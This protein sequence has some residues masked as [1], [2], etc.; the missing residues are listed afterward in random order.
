MK[1]RWLAVAVAVAVAGATVGVVVSGSGADAAQETGTADLARPI[2]PKDRVVTL[3]TGDKVVLLGGDEHKV[4]IDRGPG[5][6]HVTFSTQRSEGKL[7]VMP[8]DAGAQVAEG[9]LDRR[10]FEVSTLLKF[11]YE[12]AKT[13]ATPLII[14]YGASRARS[15]QA[16]TVR[17]NLPA[18]NGAAVSAPKTGN[19]LQQ[20]S[21]QTRSTSAIAKVWLDGKR[22]IALDQ[23]VPQ[24][25]APAAWKAGFTGKGMSVAV[26]DTGIDATHPDLQGKITAEKN[27]TT[28]NAGD[29]IG[30]GTHVASTIAGTGA[31]SNGKYKGVAPDAKLLD[32]KVCSGDDCPES[33]M[34][35]GM[36]WAA[37]DQKAKIINM[38]IGGQDTPDVDPLEEAVNRLSAQTG[39]LFVICAG[40]EGEDGGKVDSPGSADAALTVGA[41]D[42]KDQYAPFS[43]PGP[44]VGDGGLKPDITAPGVDI[45]AAKSKDSTIGDPVG[46][47]YL[48]MSGTSMATPHVA[49]SAALMLQQHPG[50]TGPELKSALM[51]TAKVLPKQTVFQQGAGRVD[52]AKAITQS[53]VA[54]PGSLSFGTQFWPHT[55]DKPLVKDL[56]YRNLGTKPVTLTLT[57]TATKAFSF[58]PT[59]LTIPAGGTGAVKVTADTRQ[60]PIGMYTGRVTATGDGQTVGTPFAIEKEQENYDVTIKHLLPNGQPTDNYVTGIV[61]LADGKIT[62]V[63]HTGQGIAKV[64]LPRGRYVVDATI[65]GDAEKQYNL[66]WPMIDLRQNTVL[67]ADAKLAKPFGITVP[68]KDAKLTEMSVGYSMTSTGDVFERST[69]TSDLSKVFVASLG[70][71]APAKNLVSYVYSRWG[72]PGK[73]GQYIDSPYAYNLMQGTRGRFQTGYQRIVD[74]KTLATVTSQYAADQ[75]G[76]IATD[77][78]L[79]GFPGMQT[80]GSI[81]SYYHRLPSKSVQYFDAGPLWTANIGQNRI[82]KGELEPLAGWT[83]DTTYRSGKSYQERWGAAVAG[84]ALDGRSTRTGSSMHV[85]LQP[86][87]DQDGHPGEAASWD[88]GLRLF[89]NGKLVASAEADELDADKLPTAKSPYRLE[90]TQKSAG[91]QLATELS[92]VWTFASAGTGMKTVPLP[93]WG[94]QFKPGVDLNNSVQRTATTNLPFV[95]KYQPKAPVGRLKSVQVW[96]SGDGGKTWTKATVV[97]KRHG[98]YLAVFKTPAKAKLI[99]LKSVVTDRSGNTATQTV[100]NAYR[101]RN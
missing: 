82:V 60:M 46:K 92:N 81:I 100:L 32:G 93:L 52:V 38:S 16:A 68:K 44:R 80:P 51:G 59:T 69:E 86:N 61:N 22:H 64:R 74:Q 1:Q 65:T 20:F 30:H 47:Y 53:V 45:V 90:H 10:L 78:R 79:G 95:V 76:G 63:F 29:N 33:Q 77:L 87:S 39:A 9:K 23:S 56:E 70:G 36:Q 94:T 31:A 17:Q 26:L 43:N 15:L 11:G 66:V 21:A 62:E 41:V 5:R 7:T 18:I 75:P 98:N 101:V 84:P 8:S 2:G 13:T 96:I 28:D 3:I 67:T 19:F 88:G 91:V 6:E 83:S 85:E 54:V 49:A 57:S 72:V 71:P 35:A 37:V 99:S 34:L 73:D 12:D 55:D 27:F 14:Q 97:P 50:W 58:S 89:R 48:K 4:R 25:G 24:I 42:K 40:N